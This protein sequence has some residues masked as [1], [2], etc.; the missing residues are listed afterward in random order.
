MLVVPNAAILTAGSHD[1]VSDEY[2]SIL[3]LFITVKR[4]ACSQD[5]L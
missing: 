2:E 5:E 3:S 4:A 1:Q